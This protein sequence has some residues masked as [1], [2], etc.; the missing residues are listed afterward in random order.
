MRGTL[1]RWGLALVLVTPSPA[2]PLGAEELPPP[3]EVFDCSRN[4]RPTEAQLRNVAL[5]F[6]TAWGCTAG[7]DP[8]P[9]P[10]TDLNG[11][12]CYCGG[13]STG[14]DTQP[15]DGYD[16]CCRQHDIDWTALCRNVADPTRPGS[17]CDCYVNVPVPIGCANR[18]P[19]FAEN[20]NTCQQ[21]CSRELVKQFTC[22][23]DV[24]TA[25]PDPPDW[26]RH[27]NWCEWQ[28]YPNEREV[29]PRVRIKLGPER[30][31]DEIL[32]S[33]CRKSTEALPTS[34]FGNYDPGPNVFKEG[35]SCALNKADCTATLTAC[36]RSAEACRAMGGQ[37]GEDCGTPAARCESNVDVTSRPCAY[38]DPNNP[39]PGQD[40][41]VPAPSPRPLPSH[42]P[43]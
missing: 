23:A 2:D 9:F 8:A 25:D 41:P 39:C 11:Y 7:T 35:C 14:L 3:R 13:G 22:Y 4:P 27:G 24:F 42:S 34:V 19:Q 38:R 30:P 26:T 37:P 28:H 40:P 6:A 21:A 12:G 36:A 31:F 33:Y 43:S 10:L 18:V 20:L 16:A 32:P 15:V 5:A 17:G 29:L 1:L